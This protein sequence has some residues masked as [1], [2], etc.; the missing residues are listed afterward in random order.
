M[1]ERTLTVTEAD[2][3]F[4][5]DVF[6]TRSLPDE[7]PSRMFVKKLMEAGRVYVNDKPVKH[8]YKVRTADMIRVDIQ[9]TDYPDERIKPE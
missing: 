5:L 9:M 1:P 8:H 4:R 2:H 7:I 3:D 6:I